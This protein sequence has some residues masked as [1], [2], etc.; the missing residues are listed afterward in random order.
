[1][2]ITVRNF[3]S[4]K[5]NQVALPWSFI[6]IRFG[7]RCT[8]LLYF[9]RDFIN[10]V[11]NTLNSDRISIFYSTERAVRFGNIYRK[12]FRAKSIIRV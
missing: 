10:A 11:A 5:S 12:E 7:I 9:V 4:A 8:M 2:E 3:P 1:M 6:C